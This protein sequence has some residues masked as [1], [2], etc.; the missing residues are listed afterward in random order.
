MDLYKMFHTFQMLLGWL[1]F[2][3]DWLGAGVLNRK[4]DWLSL[5]WVWDDT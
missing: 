5:G 1:G 2:G 3:R 4:G